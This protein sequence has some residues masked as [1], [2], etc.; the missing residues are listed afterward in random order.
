MKKTGF[1][2]LL[3]PIII[4]AAILAVIL[5]NN[6]S[7]ALLKSKPAHSVMSHWYLSNGRRFDTL[8]NDVTEPVS[9]SAQAE[10]STDGK[11]LV[12]KSENLEIT[13]FAKGKTIY[14]SADRGRRLRGRRITVIP[15]SDVKKGATVTLRLSPAE[16][17]VGKILSPIY[18]TTNN[19]FLLTLFSRERSTAFAIL[20]LSFAVV[21][22]AE[23]AAKRKS[24]APLYI[25]GE[26]LIFQLFLLCKSDLAQLF[27]SSSLARLIIANMSLWLLPLPPVLF[28]FMFVK[29]K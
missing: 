20:I 18:F 6:N 7:A 12:I 14:K 3:V 24:T 28:V 23:S 9:I 22:L 4:T 13:L 16:K 25:I 15:L 1:A 27:I 26:V 8:K 5:S 29:V 17:S 19:D 11:C 2:V 10:G 21:L